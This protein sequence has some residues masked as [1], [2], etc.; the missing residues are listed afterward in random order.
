MIKVENIDYRL[1]LYYSYLLP[2]FKIKSINNKFVFTK[3][4]GSCKGLKCIQEN[5]I[6][7]C[8]IP[9]QC[10]PNEYKKILGLN[11]RQIFD[12]LMNKLNISL[13]NMF[14][15]ITL[16]YSDNISDKKI[17]FLTIFLSS[18]T[19]YYKNTV[20][21]INY[22]LENNC[23]KNPYKCIPLIRSYQYKQFIEISNDL[24]EVFRSSSRKYDVFDEIL[25]LLR[26]RHIGLKSINAYLLHVYGNTY[27]APIDRHYKLALR[28]I[29][30]KG[31]IPS[32]KYCLLSRLHCETCSMRSRCLYY[33]SREL[34][35]KYNGVFQSISYIHGRISSICNGATKIEDLEH[36]ILG[37]LRKLCKAINNDYKEIICKIKAEF[38]EF[39]KLS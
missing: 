21:W 33:V 38:A 15:R 30:L 3:R 16:I 29:G 10:E 5:N 9:D 4:Q 7:E 19:D 1:S 22:I 32:K 13:E 34:L 39:N 28:K 26:I 27:Y 14:R 17:I 12:E 37:D 23:I 11:T 35:G 6:I 8:N 20:R 2:L 36:H 18:N 25:G 24:L 31:I